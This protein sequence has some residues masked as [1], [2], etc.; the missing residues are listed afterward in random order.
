MQLHLGNKAEKTLV[1]TR[2]CENGA[3]GQGISHRMKR[4]SWSWR[5]LQLPV[6]IAMRMQGRC[7]E[8]ERQCERMKWKEKW[9]GEDSER[10]QRMGWTE[11]TVYGEDERQRE[12]QE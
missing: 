9:R 1:I 2:E 6:S 10:E 7:V 8:R 5:E 3:R 4:E 12:A 11:G